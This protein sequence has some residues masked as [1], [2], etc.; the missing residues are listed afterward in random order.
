MWQYCVEEISIINQMFYGNT[1]RCQPSKKYIQ[2]HMDH[3]LQ[4][5]RFT[6]KYNYNSLEQIK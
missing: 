2:N 6:N 5:D 3:Q 4:N 1:L